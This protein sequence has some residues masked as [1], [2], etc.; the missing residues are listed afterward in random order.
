VRRCIYCN[1]FKEEELFSLEHIFPA[2]L[3]GKFCNDLFKT[4][5]VCKECNSKSGLFVDGP[6]VRS[7]FL[8]NDNSIF[9][10][11]YVDLNSNNS[12]YPLS[13]M[14][15]IDLP[16]LESDLV[17][18]W[19]LGLKGARYY[20]LHQYDDEQWAV[21]A[22]GNPINRKKDPGRV[23]LINTCEDVREVGLNIRTM[24]HSFGSARRYATNITIGNDS[25]KS[26]F[27]HQIDKVAQQ[28]ISSILILKD[29][30]HYVKNQVD[31]GFEQRF[32]MK[33]ARG[34]GFKILGE[35]YIDTAYA[36]HLLAGLNERNPEARRK[37]AV[38]GSGYFKTLDSQLNKIIGWEGAY[39][40]HFHVI[41][42]YFGL[43]LYL[44]STKNMHVVIS[45]EANLWT[46][47]ILK[48]Y[49]EGIIYL[50][51]PQLGM[52]VGPLDL[53]SYFAH[54]RGIV[55]IRELE[56]IEQKSKETLSL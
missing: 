32:L 35:T 8:K 17:C 39:T 23:Y 33:I 29:D 3:G 16:G 24:K 41:K 40:V 22:G 48:D 43:S 9:T 14:G 51:I 42:N 13:Y 37:L 6:F 12:I 50:I 55:S 11:K 20:H 15:R 26:P 27:L 53:P 19:W 21:C 2:A 31:V 28:E 38:R 54:R 10:L 56:Q 18:E 47:T 1:S 34:F 4:R 52:F 36:Y 30:V 5:H 49:L 7:W 44:P 45:D 25:I 46:S